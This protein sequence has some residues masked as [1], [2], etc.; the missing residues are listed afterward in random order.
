MHRGFRLDEMILI[1]CGLG[2][3]ELH[4]FDAPRELVPAGTVVLG[5]R[6]PGVDADIESVVRGE[7]DTRGGGD[8]PLTDFLTVDKERRRAALA[9]AAAVVREF[10]AH[11]ML[12]RRKRATRLDV[13]VV[14]AEQIVAVLD[15][16]VFHVE[17][18]AADVAALRDDDAVRTSLGD[19]EDGRY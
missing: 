13:E 1:V 3:R 16:S 19:L 7:D 17:R 14:D 9:H 4:A 2:H 6:R 15:P 8:P 11:L 5:D 12:A 10:H 18:P